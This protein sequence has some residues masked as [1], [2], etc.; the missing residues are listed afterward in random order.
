MLD[1]S[2]LS[3]RLD[4]A[5]CGTLNHSDGY[6]SN[7][8]FNVWTLDYHM[9]NRNQFRVTRT[10]EDHQLLLNILDEAL[11]I[12]ALPILTT[13]T[14]VIDSLEQINQLQNLHTATLQDS[15][16]ERQDMTSVTSTDIVSSVSENA[17]SIQER[18]QYTGMKAKRR[19]TNE[20]LPDVERQ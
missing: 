13:T 1:P 16:D 15:D 8:L 5:A 3:E 18:R 10:V 19:R 9:S 14:S 12:T 7:G 6:R 17:T 11:E 2:K 4:A 20:K